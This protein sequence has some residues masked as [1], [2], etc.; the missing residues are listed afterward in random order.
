M[1]PFGRRAQL[2]RGSL[3][4][5]VHEKQ[6]LAVFSVVFIDGDHSYEGV[7]T[8][9]KLA[10]QFLARGGI[11]AGH[12]FFPWCLDVMLAAISSAS[13]SVSDFH[14]GSDWTW[15]FTPIAD[16]KENI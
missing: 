4:A 6:H 9:L 1:A 13:Q 7:S 8:D 12:D 15:W 16:M 10:P 14:L 3:A 11:I 2:F 5:L